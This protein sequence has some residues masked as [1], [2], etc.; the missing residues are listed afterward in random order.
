MLQSS[1]P[2]ETLI[3]TLSI[4][5]I[6][7]SRFPSHVTS[8]PLADHPLAVLAPLLSHP[9]PA[10]RKRAILTLS[11]FVPASSPD[12]F[13]DLLK[14]NV[15]P[16]FGPGAKTEQQRTTVQLVA[17]VVRHSALQ[18]AP[19][20]GD[21]V[22]GILK[23]AQKDDDDLREGSLQVRSTSISLIHGSNPGTRLWKPC[24]SGVPSR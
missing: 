20:L 8:P 1:T 3:E 13:A 19:V 9:R 17:A 22:P 5:S 6:L 10:V 16:A 4:L 2:P 18:I 14:T 11:Q 21:I 12:L 7:I 24:C 15:L 23:A